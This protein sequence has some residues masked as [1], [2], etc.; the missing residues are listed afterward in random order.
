[1]KDEIH[2][3]L[4]KI[5]KSHRK[6][7]VELF[8]HATSDYYAGKWVSLG[9]C[10]GKFCEVLYSTIKSEVDGV[11]PAKPKKPQNFV[12]ACTALAAKNKQFGRSLCIQI[13]RVM[14]AVYEMRNNRAIGHTGGDVDPNQM[15]AEY[16]IRAQKWLMAETLRV[17]SNLTLE[18]SSNLI[19][20]VT[21]KNL[22]SVWIDGDVRRVMKP[23]LEFK[24]KTMLLLYSCAGEVEIHDLFIWSEYSSRSMFRKNIIQKLHKIAYL[25]Y[26][27]KSETV[28][29]SPLGIQYVERADLVSM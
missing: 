17:F 22:P 29:I 8:Y 28:K 27:P 12:D 5:P 9:I 4:S 19:E 10:A 11:Y 24:D 1:M 2:K 16:L 15:D 26:D 23:N 25:H 6:E 18:E 3:S 7:L 14:I 21:E 20:S 13:P